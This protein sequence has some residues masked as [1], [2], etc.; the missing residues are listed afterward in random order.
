MDFEGS[1]PSFDTAAYFAFV[2]CNKGF[3]VVPILNRMIV[4]AKMESQN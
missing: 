1:C 4:L 2:A 3:Q